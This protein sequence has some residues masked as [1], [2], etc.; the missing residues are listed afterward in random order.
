MVESEYMELSWV[1][2]LWGRMTT[3]CEISGDVPSPE[4]NTSPPTLHRHVWWSNA[5]FNSVIMRL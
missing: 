4:F 1:G 3:D 5:L 2:E